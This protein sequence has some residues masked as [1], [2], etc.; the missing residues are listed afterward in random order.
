MS[1]TEKKYSSDQDY[2][3]EAEKF[4]SVPSYDET[5]QKLSEGGK[6]PSDD[7]IRAY[8]E[9]T[10]Y[11]CPDDYTMGTIQ[12]DKIYIATT[13]AQH[14][15]FA[16]KKPGEIPPAD[17]N[18]RLSGFFSDQ[19]TVDVC[20][21]GDTLNNTKYNQM[22]QIEPYQKDGTGDATYKPH[23]DCFEIDRDKLRENYGTDD[24]NAAIA[25]CQ[26]NNQYG[27]GGSDQGFNP[28][29]DEP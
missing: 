8:R 15:R 1:D 4:Q 2:C 20:K 26:A 14:E 22:N 13:D 9:G 7:D 18:T 11:S 23:V 28:H 21:D 10:S 16:G 17:D 19:A 5:K 27:E 6:N 3:S 25:K 24:F 12:D 29:M